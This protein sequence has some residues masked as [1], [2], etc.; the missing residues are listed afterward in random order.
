MMC[1]GLDIMGNKMNNEVS[2][3]SKKIFV[4]HRDRFGVFRLVTSYRPKQEMNQN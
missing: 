1:S 3:F 2:L 4:S